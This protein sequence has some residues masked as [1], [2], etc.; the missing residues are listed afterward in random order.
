MNNKLHGIVFA[1]QSDAALQELT[2]HRHTSS[3]PF[4]GRYRLVDFVL[5]NLVNAGVSDVGLIVHTSYQS[6]LD[7]VGSGKDY[8]LSRKRGGLKI[9]PPFSY[10]SRPGSPEYAGHMDALAG[11]RS[12]L[13]RIK[14]DFVVLVGSD[15]VANLPL[16][17]MLEAHLKSGADITALCAPQPSGRSREATYLT[18]SGN[19]LV[20]DVAFNPQEADGCESLEVYI[21]SKKLLLELVNDCAARGVETFGKGVLQAKAGELRIAPF[22]FEGYFARIQSVEDYFVRSRELLEMD[23]RRDLFQPLRPIRTKDFS[24]PSTYYGPNSV[25]DS[26]LI[27]DGCIIEGSVENCILFRDVVVKKGAVVRDCVLMQGTEVGAGAQISHV[28]AD[29]NVK[30]SDGC[31]LTGHENCPIAIGKYEVV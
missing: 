20:T 15:L 7:H 24:T 23:V 16:G 10:A 31:T 9:L 5:S 11:V 2:R 1:Y 21:L 12:Y 18:V 27:A 14:Q 19:G 8:D 28:V 22:F 25:T 6:L 3:I 26:C 13:E 4:G 30:I 29:K 17:D